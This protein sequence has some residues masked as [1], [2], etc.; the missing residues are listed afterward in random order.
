MA[1]VSSGNV[2]AFYSW[3]RQLAK[4]VIFLEG[5]GGLGRAFWRSVLQVIALLGWGS[6]ILPLNLMDMM[7]SV[8][9]RMPRFLIC[10]PVLNR[11]WIVRY[12]LGSI[13]S[14]DYP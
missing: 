9:E 7:A 8:S 4:E 12:S 1:P 11:A 6:Y 13:V 5:V 14:Q 10:V 3:A 2:T